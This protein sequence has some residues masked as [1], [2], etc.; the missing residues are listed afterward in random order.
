MRRG[1][2]GVATA[3]PS[4]SRTAAVAAAGLL[5]PATM[6]SGYVALGPVT[7]FRVMV[8]A[9]VVL[10][11]VVGRP[12][13]HERTALALAGAWVALAVVSA[14][15]SP[16][17]AQW[18]VL[19]NL[20][21]AMALAWAMARLMVPEREGAE[22][23]AALTLGWEVAILVGLPVAV[24]ESRTARHLPQYIGGVWRRH[25][26]TYFEPGTFFVNP[27]YLALFLVVALPLI[28][29]R[30]VRSRGGWR[31]WHGL[32]GI[33]AA[34]L[35]VHGH[36]RACQ[37][38]LGLM[39]VAVLATVRRTR[40]PALAVLALGVVAAAWKARS[41]PA[42]WAGVASGAD[43]PATSTP[44]RVALLRTGVKAASSHP[45]LGLGP[46]G[47]RWWATHH[48]VAALHRKVDAHNALVEVATD[49]GVPVAVG[50]VAVW[51]IALVAALRWSAA[52][53]DTARVA[54][55][56]L[57]AAPAL[58]VA[59]SQLV[60]PPAVALAVALGVGAWARAS[61]SGSPGRSAQREAP[62]GP[63]HRG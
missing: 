3:G 26:N 47:F 39:V 25:P 59:N 13:P 16:A 34:G 60:G 14:S 50:V 22:T 17:P 37:A 15:V 20:V 40:V 12:W 11:L 52:G 54:V 21:V 5:A 44:I 6:L 58:S 8:A 31:V 30:L 19:G 29:A 35:L 7:A 49:Y 1:P 61:A 32:S 42:V 63:P 36:S 56:L 48:Q 33:V 43:T 53:R 55:A 27:N 51:V 57:A 23:T 46:G 41:L 38:A 18:S 9:L 10:A 62:P 2:A 28:A 4:V 45:W 24:W